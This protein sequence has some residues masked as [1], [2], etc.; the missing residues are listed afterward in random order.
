VLAWNFK[1]LVPSRSSEK[2]VQLASR[3]N[4]ERERTYD[5]NQTSGEELAKRRRLSESSL[6]SG[7]SMSDSD[8]SRVSTY[9]KKVQ[10]W[11]SAYDSLGNSSRSGLIT[12]RIIGLRQK[13]NLPL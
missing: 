12:Y 8:T 2:R 9:Q 6:K 11:M 7:L 10:I 1:L 3:K 13:A 5:W 4:R